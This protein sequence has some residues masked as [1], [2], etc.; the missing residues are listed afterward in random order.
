[1]LLQQTT[2]GKEAA[3]GQVKRSPQAQKRIS[4]S[5]PL[6]HIF[7][8]ILALLYLYPFL[9]ML[10]GSLK[11]LAGFFDGGMSLIPDKWLWGNYI[12]AWVDASFGQYF[13]NTVGITFCTVVLQ[14]LFGSMAGFAIGRLHVIGKKV[15]IGCIFFLFLLPSGYTLIPQFEVIQAMGLNNTLW[16]IIVLNVSGG[17]VGNAMFFAGYFSTMAREVEEAAVVDGA[18]VFRRYWNIALPLSTPMIATT[19]LFGFISSWNSFLIPLIYTL[20]NPDLRTLA[21]GMYAFSG[22]H[23]QQWQLTCAGAV[24]TLIPIT[25][26]FVFLQRY[27]IE[28]IAGAVK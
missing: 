18:G 2:A 28:G 1:M 14:V 6:T 12:K 22:A 10:S 27:F 15:I 5:A 26:L 19:A 24:I 3:R 17:L 13:W 25:I 7:L 11:S 9:W 8:L 23:S 16:A 21:V 20:G 4:L